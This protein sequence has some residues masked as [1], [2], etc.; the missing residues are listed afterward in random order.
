MVN[1]VPGASATKVQALTFFVNMG[2]SYLQVV[3]YQ[4]RYFIRDG[5]HRAVGLLHENIDVVPCI[6][7]DARNFD[8]VVASQPQMFLPYEVLYGQR[9]PRLSDFW[10]E[11][12]SRTVMRPA[13]RKVIR[14][15]GDEFV[16][17]G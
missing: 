8:E 3:R 5:Y 9:P 2:A 4:D 7:I 6:V 13:V 1:T 10:D 12:V 15:R 14:L 17:Q 16:V 11:A